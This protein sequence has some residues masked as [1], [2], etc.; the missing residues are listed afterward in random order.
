MILINIRKD[1]KIFKNTNYISNFYIYLYNQPIIN[2]HYIG[3]H[4]GK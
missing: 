3:V 1:S 2:W 4:G